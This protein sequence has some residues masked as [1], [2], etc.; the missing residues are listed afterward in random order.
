METDMIKIASNRNY[1][2]LK[3]SR[4]DPGWDINT[5][6]WDPSDQQGLNG[7]TYA[8]ISGPNVNSHFPSKRVGD[9]LPD[10]PDGTRGGTVA[11][12]IGFGENTAASGIKVLPANPGEPE[13]IRYVGEHTAWRTN[14]SAAKEPGP[15]DQ[16]K[17]FFEVHEPVPMAQEDMEG[18][19]NPTWSMRPSS[20]QTEAGAVNDLKHNWEAAPSYLRNIF[21][22]EE[23][24]EID[25]LMSED[26]D[27]LIATLKEEDPEFLRILMTRNLGQADLP[28]IRELIA[29]GEAH[30][31][32]T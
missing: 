24:D 21:S 10:R 31:E 22:D 18:Y 32:G 1:R 13:Y 27:S 6:V 9:Y 4:T 3:I 23:L 14:D 11:E 2:L 12:F 5:I 15:S 7:K 25:Y 29:P 28:R 30:E 16:I 26:T 20:F 8:M 17:E 19:M